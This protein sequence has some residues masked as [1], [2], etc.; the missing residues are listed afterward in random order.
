MT[1]EEARLILGSQALHLSDNQLQDYINRMQL[2]ANSWIDAYEQKVFGKTLKEL[3][4]DNDY[5]FE[6]Y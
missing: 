6:S 2:L 1:I 3:G 4:V 5:Q